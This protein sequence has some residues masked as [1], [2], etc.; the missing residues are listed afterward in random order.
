MKKFESPQINVVQFM[1]DDVITTSSGYG[2]ITDSNFD[3]LF[4]PHSAATAS[5]EFDF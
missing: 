1:N 3:N 2:N 5:D 4:A